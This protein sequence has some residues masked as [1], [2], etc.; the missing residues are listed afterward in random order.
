M[1][2][3]TWRWWGRQ[4]H[5]PAAF[6]PRKCFWYSFSLEAESTPGP[7]YGRKEMSLKN[8]VTPPEIDPETVRLVAQHLN[9]YAIH[10]YMLCMLKCNKSLCQDHKIYT[11]ITQC[12]LKRCTK[13]LAYKYIQFWKWDVSNHGSPREENANGVGRRAFWVG[14]SACLYLIFCKLI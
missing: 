11:F 7:W 6:T 8:P 2:F 12:A 14:W 10:I 9:H 4:P 3:G 5:A 1:T 13:Y